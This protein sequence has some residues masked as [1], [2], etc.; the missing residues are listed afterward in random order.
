MSGEPRL[1]SRALASWAYEAAHGNYG[2]T[3]GLP[4]AGMCGEGML[5]IAK[6]TTVCLCSEKTKSAAW[7]NT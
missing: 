7:E 1:V 3:V 6:S 2:G 4:A 5:A